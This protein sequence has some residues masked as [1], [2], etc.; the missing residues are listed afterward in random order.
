MKLA[1]ISLIDMDKLSPP[2]GLVSIA[3]YLDKCINFKNTTI[4]DANFEDIIE[5]TLEIKPDLIG[6]SAMTIRYA[7]A[8]KTAK[9][10]KEKLNVPIFIG[11]VHISTLPTSLDKVFDFGIIGEGEETILE[12]VKNFEE[13]GLKNLKKIKGLVFYENNKI[14]FTGLREVIEPI[15]KIPIPDRSFLNKEYLNQIVVTRDKKSGHFANMFTS[16]GCPYR[17][18]FCS[19]A[20]FWSKIRFNSPKRVV[21]EIKYLINDYN[22]KQISILDDLFTMNLPRLKEIAKIIKEER[23][24]EKVSFICCQRTNQLSDELF[25]LLKDIN[26]TCTYFGFE[27]GSNRM[28]KEYRKGTTVE[29]N[30]K[31]IKQCEKFGL[32]FSGSIIF[33]APNETLEDMDKSLELIDIIIKSKA[34]DNVWTMVMMPFPGTELWEVAKKRGVVSDNMDWNKFSHYKSE[35]AML[36]DK[37]IPYEEFRKRWLSSKLKLKKLIWR[38]A[39]ENFFKHPLTSVHT[40]IKKPYLIRN[41]LFKKYVVDV[42]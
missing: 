18:T 41:V 30:I 32:R 31:A 25:Q 1:L 5:R 15:D 2:M 9:K 19:T 3:T 16:R 12:V 39:R 10:I 7:E 13:N 37:E 14:T 11:G 38:R 29:Q 21:E 20:R 26:V 22:V 40:I 33:G 6:I 28:L 42:G 24:N 35:N 34:V 17:C 36:L 27:S 4:V 8:I 23:L